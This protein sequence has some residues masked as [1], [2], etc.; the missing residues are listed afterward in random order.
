MFRPFADLHFWI[1]GG[2]GEA[3]C[4]YHVSVA[5]E[6][7]FYPMY[8]P[9]VFVTPSIAGA[10]QDGKLS[11]ALPWDQAASSFADVIGAVI[12]YVERVHWTTSGAA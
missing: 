2:G 8:L 3:G 1:S 6:M 9:W 4:E 10:R 11:I 5:A 7:D 12:G